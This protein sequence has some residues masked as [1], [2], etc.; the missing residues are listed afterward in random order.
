M[1]KYP[2]QAKQRPPGWPVPCG[3]HHERTPKYDYIS[4]LILSNQST[5]MLASSLQQLYNS[6]VHKNE[7]VYVTAMFSPRRTASIIA[8]MHV[9]IMI[10]FP[11]VTK[12]LQPPNAASTN[13]RTRLYGF[14]LCQIQSRHFRPLQ[15]HLA[16]KPR[17]DYEPGRHLKG[18]QKPM[19]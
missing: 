3:P 19:L 15:V 8:L 14:K 10:W 13:H 17:K 16:D 4:G 12:C 11:S 1:K 9:Q 2:Y 6:N 18:H 7:P 5:C